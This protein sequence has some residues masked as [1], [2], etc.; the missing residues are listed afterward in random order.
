MMRNQTAHEL[1]FRF[2][3]GLCPRQGGS[4]GM[5]ER[6]AEPPFEFNPPRAGSR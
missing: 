3:R 4:R 5:F 6:G 1:A 2:E